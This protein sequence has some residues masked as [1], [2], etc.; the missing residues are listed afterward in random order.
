MI[1]ARLGVAAC[2]QVVIVPPEE[3]TGDRAE[4]GEPNSDDETNCVDEDIHKASLC[5]LL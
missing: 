3:M 4:N 1:K 5:D 2:S